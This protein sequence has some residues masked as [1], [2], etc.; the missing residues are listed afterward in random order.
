VDWSDA[1][2]ALQ[3][4]IVISPRLA[5]RP[6]FAELAPEPGQ[7]VLVVDP[8]QAFGTGSHESTR[9]AL[10]WIDALAPA[11]APGGRVLDLGTGSGVLALAA[12]AL[13]PV[14]A[15][16]LDL[17][18]LAAPEAR[19]NA[20]RNALAAR[21]R[22]WT[23]GIESVSR[24]ARFELAVANLL[25][26]E[27]E[28]V[29]AELAARIAPGGML[30]LSG[31]LAE[32]RARVERLGAEQGLACEGARER[33]DASGADWISLLMRQRSAPSSPRTRDAA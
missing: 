23:G 3:Q 25:R 28:P 14:S 12:L 18:P 11:L 2:K 4:P 10:D 9:L 16:A 19:R 33:R 8:A 5:L 27:L 1:W 17:D 21:L 6:S 20:L 7:R 13:A 15:F 29:F 32:E 22:L 30:V 31:L 26:S 24:V